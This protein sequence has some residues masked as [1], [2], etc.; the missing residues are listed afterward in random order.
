MRL[1]SLI[2]FCNVFREQ[3]DIGCN[4]S[5]A[6]AIAAHRLKIS[7]KRKSELGPS[8]SDSSLFRLANK[9]THPVYCKIKSR[10]LFWLAGVAMAFALPPPFGL[11]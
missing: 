9:E 5:P 3:S 8:H 7:F 6:Q 1:A 11:I 10:A 2:N 4:S